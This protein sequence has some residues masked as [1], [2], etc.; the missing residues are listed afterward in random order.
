[1]DDYTLTTLRFRLESDQWRASLYAE[2]LFDETIVLVQQLG[3]FYTNE[4]FSVLAPPRTIGGTLT[5]RW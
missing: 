5:Y 2:N 3:S 1:M 4:P